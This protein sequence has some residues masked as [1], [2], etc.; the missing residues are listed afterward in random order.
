MRSL[1]ELAR[2]A[3]L[4]QVAL[5]TLPKLE[6]IDQEMQQKAYDQDVQALYADMVNLS[7]ILEKNDKIFPINRIQF[8][9]LP[10]SWMPETHS[11]FTRFVE[12][13]LRTG[14]RGYI[15]IIAGVSGNGEGFEKDRTLSVHFGS[16]LSTLPS[17]A[18]Y[19]VNHMGHVTARVLYG[20]YDE[21]I[22]AVVHDFE[23]NVSSG[24]HLP[25]PQLMQNADIAREMLDFA[26]A[27]A[28][29]QV[30]ETSM[31]LPRASRRSVR[32][33]RRPRS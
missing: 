14:T 27:K 6:Q 32:G 10:H 20:G 4:V 29:E 24:E 33:R 21:I 11:V 8:T 5:E 2:H 12:E 22:K 16:R 3:H 30:V 23:N 15:E 28:S 1:K 25:L 31:V 7:N 18:S 26:I 17:E 9:T 13:N 19:T